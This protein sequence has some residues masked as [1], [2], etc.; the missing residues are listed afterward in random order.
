MVSS[1]F[2]SVI[3]RKNTYVLTLALATDKVLY[4][5]RGVNAEKVN[6]S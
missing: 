2:L 6:G 3:I 1:I 4:P 5:F